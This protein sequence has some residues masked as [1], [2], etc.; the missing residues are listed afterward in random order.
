MIYV[1][2]NK[3]IY[4]TMNAALLAYKKFAKLLSSWG[5]T[6]NPYEPCLWN[7][8]INKKQMSILFH[9]D[10]LLISHLNPVMVMLYIKKLGKEY[11]KLAVLTVCQGLV[12]EY[13]L[14]KQLILG[15]KARF[16]FFSILLY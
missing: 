11:G 4:G 6:M 15:R 8:D 16:I 14:A 7:K 1:V 10:D 3:T 9:I 2:C 5:F 12:H 13:I